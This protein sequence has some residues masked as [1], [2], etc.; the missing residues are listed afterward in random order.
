M[1]SEA[2]RR[3]PDYHSRSLWLDALPPGSLEPRPPLSSD[4]QVDVAIVGAG[5]SGLW[6]AY[7]LLRRDPSLRILVIEKDIVGFGASGRNGG[8]C[9]GELAAGPD[10]HE[11]VAGNAAARRFLSELFDSVDEV[12]RVADREGIDCHYA[13]GGTVYLA[14]NG[15][16]LARQREQV[17]ELHGRFGL[18]DADVRLLGPDEAAAHLHA[19]RVVGALFSAHT[20]ALDPALLVKGLGDAVERSGGTIVEQTAATAIEPGR[21]RTDRG[22]VTAD[23]V[24]RATEGY[25]SSIRGQ[26]RSLTPL[27]SLMVATEPLPDSLWEEIGLASRQ[28]F[29][30][31]RHLVVYGQ[32]TAD[33]RIAFGGRG[34]PYGYGSRIDAAIEQRSRTH[35]RIVEALIALLPALDGVEITHRWGGVLGVPRDWF[36]SVGFDPATGLAWAGGYVGEGVAASNLAGRTL[37]DL[38]TN[39]GSAR[40]DLPWVGHRSR[41][42]EPEPL[43]WLAIN[44]ALGAMRLADRTEARW[45]K[46]SRLAKAMWRFLR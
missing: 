19:T 4:T 37:A 12:G 40:V 15:A 33:G 43:R 3:S 17:E 21:V 34:A 29:A 24:V 6:A 25:T 39:T 11:Q 45:H 5:Y 13:K 42:W 26:A 35:D 8:W 7:Y 23:V 31:S 30:D 20:A 16:H 18:T 41:R 36:P 14:R 1:M 9:V 2:D 38:I 46:D 22:T 28:T 44:G 32:R 10:R 27:Y